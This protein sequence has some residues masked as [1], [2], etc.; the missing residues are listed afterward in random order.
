MASSPVSCA[1]SN[2]TIKILD[3][4]IGIAVGV[5]GFQP[6]LDAQAYVTL[7]FDLGPVVPEIE[8]SDFV[9]HE[10]TG[11]VLGIHRAARSTYKIRRHRL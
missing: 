9:L 4:F 10:L 6:L 5:Q 1:V 11:Q 2:Q 8:T 3:D 7:F